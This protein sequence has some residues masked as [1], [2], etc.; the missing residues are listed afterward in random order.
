MLAGAQT[1]GISLALILAG[2]RI[3]GRVAGTRIRYS[4]KGC[5]GLICCATPAVH[6]VFN[7]SCQ[8]YFQSDYLWVTFQRFR[9]RRQ[10]KSRIDPTVNLFACIL[11]QVFL[12]LFFLFHYL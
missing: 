7:R 8:T 5:T 1:I 11:L 4:D 12:S 9:K 10:M 6:S 3:K 2:N